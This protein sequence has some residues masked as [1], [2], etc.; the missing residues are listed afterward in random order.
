MADFE[1]CRASAARIVAAIRRGNL[2]AE[3]VMSM[4]QQPVVAITGASSGMGKAAARYFAEHGWKVFAGA[5]R[6]ELIPHDDAGHIVALRLDVTDVE[7][8][9]GFVAAIESN[10]GR[11]D[12]LINDAGFSAFGPVEAMPVAA[13]RALFETNVLGAVQLTQL[14]LP[15]MRAQGF[16]RIVNVSSISAD[17]Y[18]PFGAAYHASKAAL[19]TWS[20]TLDSEIRQFGLRSVVVQPGAVSS[21]AWVD[22]VAREL[23]DDSPYAPLA[24]GMQR[25]FGRVAGAAG[26]TPEDLAKTFYRA[27]TKR[28]RLRS[29][30]RSAD[31]LLVHVIHNHPV[32]YSTVCIGGLIYAATRR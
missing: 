18:L 1:D 12:A 13:V 16:G 26:Q 24:R 17:M 31:A 22:I 15:L 28:P 10:G 25:V 8:C 3:A 5:R 29:H 30:S 6:L 19:Q 4:S 14:V 2:K 23:P 27:A 9:R 11:V 20:D 21:N 32:I 7:T